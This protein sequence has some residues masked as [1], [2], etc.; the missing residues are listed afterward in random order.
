MRFQKIFLFYCI[1]VW[2]EGSSQSII[3]RPDKSSM[4]RAVIVGI[5]DYQDEGIPDLKY[6]H[7]DAI[8]F[9]NYLKSKSGGLLKEENIKI[10]T[11]EEATGGN[12]HKALYWL[13]KESKKDDNCIIYFS[14]HGDVETIYEDEPGHLLVYDSPSSI[15]QINS[16]RIEDLNRILNSLSTK[17]GAKV[18]I[19]TDACHS[20]KLSGSEV[21]GSQATASALAKQFNNEIKIMSCQ[22]NEYSIEGEQWGGGRGMFSFHLIEALT[23]LADNNDDLEVDLKELQRYLEDRFEEDL[24]N[25]TQT[26]VT[27]GDRNSRISFVDLIALE[28]I[29]MTKNIPSD[30]FIASKSNRI[31]TSSLESDFYKALKQKY[32]MDPFTPET[33]SKTPHS[34]E[35][36]YKQ[37]EREEIYLE[38][39]PIYKGD[40]IAALQNDAQQAINQYLK[41]DP[42][43]FH[44]R[45]FGDV[46]QYDAFPIYLKKSAELLGEMHYLFPQIKAKQL[47]FEVVSERIKLDKIN[48]EPHLYN[49]LKLK[50]IEALKFQQ[51]SPFILNELGVACIR[52]K[53]YSEGIDYLKQA[54]SISPQWAMPYNNLSFIYYNLD[55]YIE[56][57]ENAELALQLNDAIISPYYNLANAYYKKGDISQSIDYSFR[58]LEKFNDPCNVMNDIGYKYFTLEEYNQAKEYYS[59]AIECDSSLVIAYVNQSLL[60]HKLGNTHLAI[61][62]LNTA[63]SKV[64]S[65]DKIYDQIGYLYELIDEKDKAIESYENAIKANLENISC[66]F[67]MSLLLIQQ[68]IFDEAIKQLDIYINKKGP[69]IKLAYYYKATANA[70]KGNLISFKENML[71]AIKNGFKNKKRMEENKVLSSIKN[72]QEYLEILSLLE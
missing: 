41:L 43:A 5:S 36:Y 51:R 21:K 61:T 7:K 59:K 27:I 45:L 53:N 47:Y 54:I 64:K 34:A 19:Y 48:S 58:I 69:Q 55:N 15:Y 33:D 70:G 30:E 39:L 46:T 10:Y 24:K 12:I 38:K 23:G 9:S 57:I 44:N 11:N 40:F 31:N 52:M 18:T 35:Y 16:V 26:P 25:E 17:I 56:A 66:R 49:P 71:E 6:A 62:Q 67:Y 8:A 65:P 32:L 63:L 13:V 72:K 20:G 50:L 2:F 42:D 3:Q 28:S 37:L 14:G 4:T 60:T 1:L 68:S 22:A 29:K